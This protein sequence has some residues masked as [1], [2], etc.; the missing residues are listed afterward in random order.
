MQKV[1]FIIIILFTFFK[2]PKS[3][4][5]ELVVT[6]VATGIVIGIIVEKINHSN[7]DSGELESC[8]YE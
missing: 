5:A 3:A 8:E 4:K 2:S 6:W 1:F 7:A